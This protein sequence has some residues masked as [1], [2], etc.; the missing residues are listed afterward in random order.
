[1]RGREIMTNFEIKDNEVILKGFTA[2]G[3]T[4]YIR[5]NIEE[6][7]QARNEYIKKNKD[8]VKK[9]MAELLKILFGT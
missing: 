6:V 8:Y 4:V 5:L 7:M 1:M 3:E 9:A 2:G